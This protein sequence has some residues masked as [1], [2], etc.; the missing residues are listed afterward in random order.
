VHRYIS[1]LSSFDRIIVKDDRIGRGACHLKYAALKGGQNV[2]R[3]VF[4]NAISKPTSAHVFNI[5]APSLETIISREVLWTS[6]LTLQTNLVNGR[7]GVPGICA[8]NC[9]VTDA[10]APSPLHQLVNTMTATIN[11]NS[12]SMNVQEVLPALLNTCAPEEL[13]E[14]DSTTPTTLGYLA[15][16]RDGVQPMTYQ[17]TRY[18]PASL[19][20]RPLI[21]IPGD[22]PAGLAGATPSQASGTQQSS[23]PTRHVLD[24]DLSR[25]AV[26]GKYRTTRGS[27]IID[28]I[29]NQPSRTVGA[30]PTVGD[31]DVCVTVTLTEPLRLSPF[32]L[33]SP[34]EK[35]GSTGSPS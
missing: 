1:S 10:L 13:A 6:T 17:L 2:A 24:H 22:V 30:A 7:G 26:G 33:G 20:W 9:G 27:F 4:F 28:R 31:N 15:S 19:D 23:Y 32:V 35:A 3:Q 29:S 25:P 14:H 12:V 21:V 11:N 18:Q 8:V 16:Y 34:E 5:A